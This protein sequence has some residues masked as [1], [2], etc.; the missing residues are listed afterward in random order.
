MAFTPEMGQI[1]LFIGLDIQTLYILLL[2]PM[3]RSSY[4]TVGT[5]TKIAL[6]VKLFVASFSNLDFATAAFT[7]LVAH[8][9]ISA[10]L[11]S[12]RLCVFLKTP[13]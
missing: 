10:R 6:L 2:D 4:S 7:A 5:T 8:S 11:R 1:V 13:L 12:I 9:S 3:W